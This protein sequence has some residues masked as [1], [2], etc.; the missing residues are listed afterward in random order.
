MR[1]PDERSTVVTRAIWAWAWRI[2]ACVLLCTISLAGYPLDGYQQTGIRRLRGYELIHEGVLSGTLRLPAGALFPSAAIGLRLV[3]RS[4]SFDITP[5]TE[6]DPVLQAGLDRIVGAAHASYRVAMVDITDP[7]RPR[8]AA[9][10]ADQG[11]IPGSVGK[12]LVMA[13]LFDQLR[14]LHPNDIAARVRVLRDTQVVADRFALPNSHAVPI[15][16]DGLTAVT[17]RA[18]EVGDTFSLWEWVDHMVS[19]SSNAAGSVVWKQALLLEEFGLAYPPSRADEDAF[20][21]RTP[22][23]ELSARSVQIL[24][25]PLR[26]AGLDVDNLR[27]GTY[28]TRGASQVIPGTASFSTPNQLVRWLIRLERGDL[29]DRW[30]SLEMKKLMYFTRNRYRFAASPALASSRVF[31]KSGSLFE[32]EPELGFDCRQYQGNR[33]NLMH[34]VAIVETDRADDGSPQVY[35]ISMMSNVLRVNSAQEHLQL[36]TAI[37][38]LVEGRLP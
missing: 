14:R 33:T 36:G 18:V 21:Q 13:G 31:F 8:Y 3:D 30:S 17:H 34:S 6:V 1:F 19:P 25:A 24:E 10:R 11:Y 26:R 15:V 27:L 37:H 12:L 2:A 32:C 7:A 38:R 16:S 29:V 5:A 23:A 4:P 20:F 22:K 9:V 28:F 35:L